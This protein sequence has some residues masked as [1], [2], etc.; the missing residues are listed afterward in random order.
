M[1]KSPFLGG[2]G[3]FSASFIRGQFFFFLS[4]LLVASV[5]ASEASHFFLSFFLL[6][7]NTSSYASMQFVLSLRKGGFYSLTSPFDNSILPFNLY[8]IHN[9]PK[10]I[11]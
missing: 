6:L 8:F 4:P 3:G 1:K 5:E 9:W 2:F 11:K 10:R 7:P